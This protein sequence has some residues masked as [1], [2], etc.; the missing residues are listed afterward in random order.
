MEAAKP[1]CWCAGVFTTNCLKHPNLDLA[2]F[3]HLSSASL[4]HRGILFLWHQG[5]RLPSLSD[6]QWSEASRFLGLEANSAIHFALAFYSV[7]YTRRRAGWSPVSFCL[8]VYFSCT[9]NVFKGYIVFMVPWDKDGAGASF[10]E[11]SP[12]PCVEMRVTFMV[13]YLSFFP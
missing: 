2:E 4:R 10:N 8:C 1:A 9:F 5:S 7:I 6:L 3:L 11:R 13:G 12:A